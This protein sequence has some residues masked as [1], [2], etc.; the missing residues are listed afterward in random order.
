MSSFVTGCQFALAIV[1]GA[2]VGSFGATA[3]LRLAAG[4][5]PWTGRSRC[6]GCDRMLGW[7]E[8]VP[9]ASFTLARGRCIACGHGIDKFHLYGEG[10][11]IA[12]A[13]SAWTLMPNRTGV[14]LAL[15][16]L[17]LLGQSLI[18]IK[19]LRLPD[20]GNFIVA[21][22]CAFLAWHSHTLIEGVIAA[23]VSGT[24]LY[25]LKWAL[26]RKDGRTVLGFGDIKLVMALALALGHW[27]ALMLVMAS[28]I[29]LLALRAKLG[30][31]DGRL[32]FGPAIAVSA[33]SCLMILTG[34]TG[35]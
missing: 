3:A 28:L 26:E 18:N 30:R 10:F 6:D 8:T 5:N 22:L 2:V 34:L 9:L 20:V 32:P 11:G 16:G 19:T 35:A 29:G 21:G 1:G 7:N 14:V 33:F 23:T 17:A 4:R 27:T 25:I 31:S 15:L 13:F 12:I 24:I